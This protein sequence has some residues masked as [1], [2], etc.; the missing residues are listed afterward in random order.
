[1]SPACLSRSARMIRRMTNLPI[2]CTLTSTELAA[3]RTGL[4]A[5]VRR[6]CTSVRLTD[7]GL[8]LTFDAAPGRLAQLG[9]LI[10]LERQCCRFLRFR[11]E[12]APDDGPVRLELSGPSGTGAFLASIG[13]DASHATSS[14]LAGPKTV[15]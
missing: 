6:A 9:E 12:A 1:M 7:D 14:D 8:V 3:R 5:D 13:L 15:R 10:D 2:V 11:L 4:L